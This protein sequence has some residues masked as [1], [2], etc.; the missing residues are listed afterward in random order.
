M[1]QLS[2]LGTPSLSINSDGLK[3]ASVAAMLWIWFDKLCS[4]KFVALVV[5]LSIAILEK[6]N[7]AAFAQD[8]Q[9]APSSLCCH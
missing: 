1:S 8:G 5:E 6:A 7:V 9:S 2:G 4:S 3:P